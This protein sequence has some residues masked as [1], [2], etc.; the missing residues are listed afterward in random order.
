MRKTQRRSK[1]MA[2]R[3]QRD[4][5]RDVMLSAR[6]CETWLT[7]DELAQLTHYPSASISAQLQHLRK[8]EH[9]RFVV[10]KRCLTKKTF[11][12]QRHTTTFASGAGARERRSKF[13]E[14]TLMAPPRF[15]HPGQCQAG[16]GV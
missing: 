7:L 12:A 8:P 14:L 13:A 10:E 6:E 16:A 11:S 4:V 9:G 5:L 1:R 2:R 3:R 15:H